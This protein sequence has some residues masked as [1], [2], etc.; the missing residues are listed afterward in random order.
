MKVDTA[1]LEKVASLARLELTEKEKKQFIPEF[2]EILE[3]CQQLDKVPT[4]NVKPSF[5]PVAFT[6][7]MREDA[8]E[9]C[10][11]QEDALLNASEKKEGYI[12]GPK[13]V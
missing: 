5:Q 4:K 3:A 2:K 10:L 11:S 6:D 1:L 13:V 12:K 7:H 8:V 9:T